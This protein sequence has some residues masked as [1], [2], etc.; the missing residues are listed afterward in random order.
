MAAAEGERETLALEE[1]LKSTR[2]GEVE[3]G[4]AKNQFRVPEMR[5]ILS[6]KTSHLDEILVLNQTCWHCFSAERV[7]GLLLWRPC[8]RIGA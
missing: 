6:G 4:E 2:E 3:E 1:R 8:H 7:M 5:E